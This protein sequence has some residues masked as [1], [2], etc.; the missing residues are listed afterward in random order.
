[1][2]VRQIRFTLD[3][4]NGEIE[5]FLI[6]WVNSLPMNERGVIDLKSHIVTR[7]YQHINGNNTASWQQED[8]KDV[9]HNS[10]D[11]F[12]QGVVV[13]IPSDSDTPNNQ[14]ASKEDKFKSSVK[15]LNF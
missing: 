5:A 2:T 8:G 13:D 1:M 12:E 15:K 3:S 4:K 7:L 11:L 10:K 6:E 14:T 9:R